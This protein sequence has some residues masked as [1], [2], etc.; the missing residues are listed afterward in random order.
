V[1]TLVRVEAALANLVDPAQ[2]RDPLERAV[3]VRQRAAE[4]L[5]RERRHAEAAEQFDRLVPICRELGRPVQA[6]QYA[7]LAARYGE[8]LPSGEADAERLPGLVGRYVAA[9][10]A[11]TA[12]ERAAGLY[13]PPRAWL[14]E[15]G[16]VCRDDETALRTLL[17]G[18]RRLAALSGEEEDQR[19]VER[20]SE[21]LADAL[22]DTGAWAEALRVLS[23][24]PNPPPEKL[25]RCHEGLKAWRRAADARLAANQPAEALEDYRRAAAFAEAATLAAELDRSDLA[26]MLSLQAGLAGTLERLREADLDAITEAEATGLARHLREAA[27]FVA[28]RPKRGQA[29]S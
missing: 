10:E 18:A 23:T 26:E 6:E 17:D 4:A 8:A 11:L 2:R 21:A 13:A 3:E 15:A 5:V 16:T 12:D 27:D 20:L 25:A 29:R 1:R 19:A 28:R 22:L 7:V 24:E 9:L 14:D